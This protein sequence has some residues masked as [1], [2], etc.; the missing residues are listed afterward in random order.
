ML[1]EIRCEMFREKAIGF[2]TGLNVILG[3]SVATNSIGK[4]TLLMVIDF[5]YGGKSF[6]QHNKDV[7]EE[8]GHH[9]YF[10]T[11]KFGKDSFP[12]KRG[13]F[14]PDLIYRCDNKYAEIEPISIENYTT[15]LK[16][17]YSL[18]D[19]DLSFRSI[20]SLFSR[21]WGKEN[22]DV[23]H[24]LHSFKRQKPSDCITNTIKLFKKYE[25]IRLLADN[26]KSKSEEIATINK[27][28]KTGLIS[29][30]TKTKYKENITKIL[31]I[32]AEIEEIKN[33]LKKY[34]VNISEIANREVMELKIEKDRLLSE[35]LRLDSRLLRVRNDLKQNKA[36]KSKHL[37][38][39]LKY[40]P[41]VST[42]RL[43]EV[44]SFHSNIT[45][46]LRKELKSSE[47]EL[48]LILS[49]IIEEIE[50]IDRKISVSL[51]EIDN[52]NVVID[53]VYELSKDHSVASKEIEYF[54]TDAQIK[55]DLRDAK[56]LLAAEKIRILKL[57]ENILNDKNRK[58]VTEIYSEERRSPT[59]KLGQNNYNFEL[60]ED[61]GTGKAYSNLILLDLAFLETTVLP[62]LIHDSVLFKNIQ[63][64]A[65]AKLIKLYEST[66]KQ[67][68]IAIDEIEKYGDVAEKK[69]KAKKVIQLD[70]NKVLYI[71]D[72]RK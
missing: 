5:I 37:E 14:K 44:E 6:L 36:I 60:V 67:T 23:K 45:K 7:I 32:D 21:V 49:S 18:G 55:S 40:F 41:N 69:L 31:T 46:I 26:V 34:A 57:I 33:N 35:K 68:F 9:E 27:A 25:P 58:N 56:E 20:V 70:N 24:P 50:M 52:P 71:K 64:D 19:V 30:T 48:T 51:A 29:K 62:F 4:S 42:S 16:A 39:L 59:L 47:A 61:T 43:E 3:D 53:R 10:F 38:P 65:V 2:H 11:F 15:F 66:G 22:L 17:S 12:F 54:E 8:L 63:N 28:A 72:W 13:T 1:T